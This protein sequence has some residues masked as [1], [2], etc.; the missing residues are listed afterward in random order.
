MVALVTPVSVSCHERKFEPHKYLVAGER[1]RVK[2]G[3]LEGFEGVIIRKKS[4]LYIVL[5]LDR[6][7][8]SVAVEV[9]AE[10]LELARPL[11]R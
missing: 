11:R 9:D 3:V 4:N 5:S 8:Q 7:M 2:S 1:A 6:I 10:K